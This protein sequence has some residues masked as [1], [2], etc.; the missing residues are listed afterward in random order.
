VSFD[1]GFLFFRDG[2][3]SA[4]DMN[5]SDEWLAALK[6]EL[7]AELADRNRLY[8][9]RVAKGRMTRAEADKETRVWRGVLQAVDPFADR[10]GDRPEATWTEQVHALRREIALRRHFY[11]QWILT[12]RIHADA[13]ERKLLLLEQWHDLLWYQIGLPEAVAA[14]ADTAARAATRQSQEDKRAAA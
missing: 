5:L 4:R 12:G 13:A 6:A 2:G 3:A 10:P 1:P 9:S 8:P 11:P 14:R 7:R